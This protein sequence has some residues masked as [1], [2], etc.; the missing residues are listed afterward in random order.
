MSCTISMKHLILSALLFAVNGTAFAAEDDAQR[1]AMK[2]FENEVR[3]VLANR[4][5]ECHGEKKKKGSLRLDHIDLITKGGDSGPALVPGR[6]DDSLIIQGIR[7][8]DPDF[9]MPPKKKLPDKEIAVLEKWVKLGAP[10]PA[11]DKSVARVDGFGFTDAQRKWW[12]FQPLTK[13][14]PPD[15]KS[16]WVRNDIDKFIGS[17]GEATCCTARNGFFETSIRVMLS[18]SPGATPPCRPA[19]PALPTAAHLPSLETSTA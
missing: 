2:F 5:F 19:M 4:C 16:G 11:N 12:C 8:G 10:W 17:D 6:P 18:L 15:V 9:E 14:A 7:Y 3:P 13:P 1:E